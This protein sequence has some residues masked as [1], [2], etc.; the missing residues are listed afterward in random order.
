MNN[1]TL[2]SDL[3]SSPIGLLEICGTDDFITTIQFLDKKC[4]DKM[5]LH[6][7]LT[8]S[9]MLGNET[10]KQLETYFSGKRR[11]FNL[12][13]HLQGTP[14]QLTVWKTLQAIP[15][16][17]TR[18]YEDIAKAIGNPKAARSVG[19]ANNK[20]P[21]AIAIPCHRVIGKNKQL[22]GYAWGIQSKQML[23]NLENKNGKK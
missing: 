23:L 19:Q 8:R 3:Y 16:G 21:F 11:V 7:P 20:N 13:L 9:W 14:F 15:Y 2:F 17:E 6:Q 22:T 5:T 10:K 4:S 1:D 18:T 12:P